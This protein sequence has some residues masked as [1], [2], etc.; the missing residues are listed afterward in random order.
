MAYN[1]QGF[2]VFFAVNSL[3]EAQGY[4]YTP[5]LLHCFVMHDMTSMYVYPL[6]RHIST[7]GRFDFAKQC[8]ENKVGVND[9]IPVRII[10]KENLLYGRIGTRMEHKNREKRQMK[11]MTE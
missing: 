4:P 8:G 5:W 7:S 2:L 1:I 3:E 9:I 10:R 6:D 11:G